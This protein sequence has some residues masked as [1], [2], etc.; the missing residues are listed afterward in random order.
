MIERLEAIQKDELEV[1]ATD[2][3]FLT[4]EMREAELMSEGKAYNEAHA[5]TCKEYGI[6]AEMEKKIEWRTSFLY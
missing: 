6:T 1:T 5:Q 4:H 3:A 2:K